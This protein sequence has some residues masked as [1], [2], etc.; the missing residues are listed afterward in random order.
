MASW[1]IAFTFTQAFEVPVYLRATG[2]WRTAFLASALT[3]PAVWFLFPALLDHGLTYWPMV[4]AAEAFAV[5]AEALWL[6]VNGVPRA[7]LWSFLANTASC[8]GGLLLRDAFGVP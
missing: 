4:G 3:H 2:N 7:L 8:V 1:L 6:F 5:G